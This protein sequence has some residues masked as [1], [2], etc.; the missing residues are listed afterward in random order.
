MARPLTATEEIII[1]N[2][3]DGLRD[4]EIAVRLSLTVGDVQRRISVLLHDFRLASRDELL[5]WTPPATDEAEEDPVGDVPVP[6]AEESAARAPV[7]SLVLTAFTLLLGAT[8]LFILQPW[9][10]DTSRPAIPAADAATTPPPAPTLPSLPRPPSTPVDFG[11]RPEGVDFGQ[12]VSIDTTYALLISAEDEDGSLIGLDRVFRHPGGGD[13][14]RE[15]LWRPP[16]G[17][18]ATGI[19]TGQ[20]GAVAVTYE[21]GSAA[22]L[23][24][25]HDGG[26]TW[27]GPAPVAQGVQ[28][29]LAGRSGAVLATGLATGS[30][31]LHD[32]ATT[33]VLHPPAEAVQSAPVGAGPGDQ[34]LW[35]A[36]DGLLV[37]EAG[38]PIASLPTGGLPVDSVTSV[39]WLPEHGH[40]LASWRSGREGYTTVLASVAESSRTFAGTPGIME[41][42]TGV[43]FYVGNYCYYVV[44]G[45]ASQAPCIPVLLRPADSTVYPIQDPLL[46]INGFDQDGILGSLPGPFALVREQGQCAPLYSAFDAGPAECAAPGTLLSLT[47][48]S[49]IGGNG[50]EMPA[51]AVHD[52]KYYVRVLTSSGERAWVATSLVDTGFPPPINPAPSP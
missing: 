41:G 16:A 37:S 1:Q 27:T 23:T 38:E 49:S 51:H 52:G 8:V 44:D 47:H 28:P 50:P 18:R 7:L 5:D 21:A 10:S 40:G 6:A 33:R 45:E 12:A 17:S 31:E 30:Y 42:G 15:P 9:T 34:L 3:R 4:A 11:P 25:S 26:I 2:L 35:H 39:T 24:L 19:V 32:G 22:W 13:A 36:G 29:I 20:H 46:S 14:L 43:G 48:F